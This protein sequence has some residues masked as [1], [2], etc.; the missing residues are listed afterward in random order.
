M[1]SVGVAYV[2]RPAL[3]ERRESVRGSH[4]DVIKVRK[5]EI[6]PGVDA[7]QPIGSCL[8]HRNAI[9]DRKHTNPRSQIR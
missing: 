6:V 3:G 5:M 9:A 1:L 7:R 4:P 2:R 8:V